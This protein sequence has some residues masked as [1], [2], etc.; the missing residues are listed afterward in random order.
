LRLRSEGKVVTYTG[1]TQWTDA[2]IAAA[3]GA[4]LLIAEAYFFERRI[5]WHL[6]WA[7]LR[8]HLPAIGA[9]RVILTHMGPDMLA[10]R[11]ETGCETAEDGMVVEV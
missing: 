6:D 11:H 7:S 5:K 2:L 3:E 1:D 9:M 10:R 8:D 4:D